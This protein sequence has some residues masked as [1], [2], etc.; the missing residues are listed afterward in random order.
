MSCAHC[1]DLE[2]RVAWL[3][4]ELGIQTEASLVERIR[5]AIPRGTP[6]RVSTARLVAALYRAHGRVV[7]RAQLLE[8]L[9]PKAGGEDERA[10]EIINVWAAW[11]RK[12]LGR[13]AVACAWGV[14]YRLTPEGMERVR[15]I[16]Q[17]REAA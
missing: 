9:P 4:S 1:A 7:S 5:A 12:A 13:G 17:P 15:L 3:E 6:G 10:P 11:A 14:G 2:E 8:A 16:L